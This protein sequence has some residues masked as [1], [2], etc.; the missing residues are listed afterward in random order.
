MCVV[1]LLTKNKFDSSHS[2]L[3]RRQ[4]FARFATLLNKTRTDN[5]AFVRDRRGGGDT[6]KGQP[7]ATATS[8]PAAAT[9]KL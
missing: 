2:T 8:R 7:T 1:V 4:I 3:S 6:D 5:D 9:L